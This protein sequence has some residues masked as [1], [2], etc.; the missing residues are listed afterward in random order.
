MKTV[1]ATIGC[2]VG[3]AALVFFVNAVAFG[4]YVFWAPKME[5]ARRDVMIQSRAY[6]EAE[7]RRLYDMQHQ[8]VTATTDAEKNIIA[9]MARHEFSV[10]DKG[11]LP[12]DLLT[13]ANS[14]GV[15]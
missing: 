8:Y 11:R 14:I 4:N 15:Y 5:G 9:A 3:F 1:L 10:F 2:I 12:P 13:F 7:V 6:G